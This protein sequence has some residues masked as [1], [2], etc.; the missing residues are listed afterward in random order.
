MKYIY[1]IFVIFIIGVD[2]YNTNQLRLSDGNVSDFCKGNDIQHCIITD[3]CTNNKC[4]SKC[5]AGNSNTGLQCINCCCNFT[6][7]CN[8]N[9]IYHATIHNNNIYKDIINKKCIRYNTSGLYGQYIYKTIGALYGR[10]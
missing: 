8:D 6:T 3:T 9:F 7:Y 2:S 1:L 5:R 4:L 10:W